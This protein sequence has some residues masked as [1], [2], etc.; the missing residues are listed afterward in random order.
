MLI[1]LIKRL[2]ELLVWKVPEQRRRELRVALFD[3]LS[4]ATRAA[5]EG[6]ARGMTQ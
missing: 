6:A 4:Q 1:A 3:L 2:F 5:A